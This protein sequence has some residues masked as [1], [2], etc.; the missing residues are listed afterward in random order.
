[1]ILVFTIVMFHV[2]YSPTK[3][4]ENGHSFLDFVLSE[5]EC[6]RMFRYLL[7]SVHVFLAH[8]AWLALYAYPSLFSCYLGR[9]Y[10]SVPFLRSCSLHAGDT[11]ASL[12]FPS[13]SS[14]LLHSLSI[15]LSLSLSL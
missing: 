1:M 11:T 3:G 12:Y 14:K 9:L 2:L 5:P 7:I 13:S 6:M 4:F 15:S 10:E 8:S